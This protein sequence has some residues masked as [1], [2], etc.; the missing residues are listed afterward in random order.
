YFN[1]IGTADDQNFGDADE[2]P[3][4]QHSANQLE[5]LLRLRSV[6]NPLEAAIEDVISVIGLIRSRSRLSQLWLAAQR[7]D[8]LHRVPPGKRQSLN[9]QTKALSQ[10]LDSDSLFFI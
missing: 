8:A 6:V 2:Q 9:R 3:A 5:P 7:G 4:F 10:P 1:P